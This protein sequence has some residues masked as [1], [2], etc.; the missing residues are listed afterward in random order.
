MPAVC[1]ASTP[2]TEV[3]GV[4]TIQDFATP[5]A[6]D[7]RRSIRAIPAGRSQSGDHLRQTDATGSTGLFPNP[8]LK[9][10]DGLG[11][12]PPPRFSLAGEAESEKLSLPRLSHGA[13]RLIHLEL[14]SV[15]DEVRNPLHHSLSRSF[16]AHVN[17]TV[18]SAGESHP[19]ALSE[20]YVNL[21]AHTAP[22]VEPRRTPIC[23]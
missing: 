5:R 14:E 11:G 2:P 23:Q 22:A 7:N 19:R 18:S 9:A 4:A 17:V 16:A 20:P 1:I 6:F 8:L 3:G 13:L 12:D 21:S 15:R 10:S